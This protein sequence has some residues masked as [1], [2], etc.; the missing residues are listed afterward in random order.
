MAVLAAVLLVGSGIL[1]CGGSDSPPATARPNGPEQTPPAGPGETTSPPVTA[2]PRNPT[3]AEDDKVASTVLLFDAGTGAIQTLYRSVAV[4]AY[5]AGFRG[6]GV[7]VRVGPDD[8]YFRLDGS[9]TAG[10]TIDPTCT[11]PDGAAVIAGKLYPGVACGLR[12]VSPDGRWLTYQVASGEVTLPSGAVVGRSD[13]WLLELRSGEARLV[14]DGLVS[15]GGCDG[16]Y[17]PVWSPTSRYV[18]YAESG[19]GRRFLTDVQTGVT[20]S[21]GAGSDTTLAP[22]WSPV[23]E[24]V[25]YNVARG[26]PT[27][28][29]DLQAGTTRTIELAWPVAFDASGALLYSPAWS[30]GTKEVGLVTTVM[31]AASGVVLLRLPGAPMGFHAWAGQEPIAAVGGDIRAALQQVPG[32][33]GV[34]IYMNDRLEQCVTAGIGASVSVGG[35]VAVVRLRPPEPPRSGHPV[36]SRFDV[37]VIG[38]SSLR[39]V[40]NALSPDASPALFW[41]P[42]GTKLLIFWPPPEGL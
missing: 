13:M 24:S 17:G 19:G 36:P 7:L 1:A 28:I 2:V 25:L 26:G 27:V 18:A 9:P 3:P 41:S 11:G 39:V 15:C 6:D 31:D 38:L 35:L 12:S 10:P 21:I 16:R 22:V 32:C 42:D 4:R 20:R 34:G 14:Q 37:E 29:E 23:G 33:S 30:P 40:S 5:H 8:L